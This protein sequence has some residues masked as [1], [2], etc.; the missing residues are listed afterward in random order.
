MT[1]TQDLNQHPRV[2]ALLDCFREADVVMRELR[3]Y[4]AEVAIEAIDFRAFGEDALIGVV[5]TP[6]FMNLVLLPV[7]PEPMRM[8]EIGRPVE[9]ALPVGKRTFVIGG[10]D[11]VGLYRAH[12]LHS[13]VLT[14]TLPGQAQ[15]EARRQLALLMTPPAQER[16]ANQNGIGRHRSPP[17]AVRTRGPSAIRPTA[18]I[19]STWVD[20]APG[21]R[22]A[23]IEAEFRPVPRMGQRRA[24]RDQDGRGDQKTNYRCRHGVEPPNGERKYAS[25][26]PK[27]V[28][29]DQLPQGLVRVASQ[30]VGVR[31]RCRE[32]PRWQG[33]LGP[34]PTR[35]FVSTPS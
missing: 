21:M 23:G 4:N 17:A 10:N 1:V 27:Y 15:A 7:A 19:A 3:L 30:L 12:S 31:P 8:A 32:E 20:A 9:V 14:F 13:P 5:L 35:R 18:V 28:D 25:Q 6:W 11:V 16:A 22:Q 29:V 34:S 2:S 26:R 33:S 24:G